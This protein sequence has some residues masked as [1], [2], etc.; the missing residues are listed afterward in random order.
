MLA[1]VFC[2]TI[3]KYRMKKEIKKYTNGQIVR[4]PN[5]RITVSKRGEKICVLMQ[6]ILTKEE[7]SFD[8]NGIRGN[9]K[10]TCFGLSKEAALALCLSLKEVLSMD[11][12]E[13]G[14]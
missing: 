12:S 13:N 4:M 6:A 9:Y 2:P 14:S 8:G 5:K 10:Q 1:A 11:D 3:K 7:L